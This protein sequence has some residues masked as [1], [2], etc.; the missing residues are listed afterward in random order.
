LS[1]KDVQYSNFLLLSKSNQCCHSH[2]HC[3]VCAALAR[4]EVQ[5]KHVFFVFPW[6]LVHHCKYYSLCLDDSTDITDVCQLMIFVWT[7]DKNFEIKEEFLK[8]QP[9]TTGTKM[10]LRQSTKLFLDLLH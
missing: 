7:I 5:R 10:H 6:F 4:L 3:I 8:L 1:V 2:F 9:L